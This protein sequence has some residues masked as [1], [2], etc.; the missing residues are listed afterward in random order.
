[1]N[2]L[3]KNALDSIAPEI[4][5]PDDIAAVLKI[6]AGS[7]VS[8]NSRYKV[9]FSLTDSPKFQENKE[10]YFPGLTIESENVFVSDVEQPEKMFKGNFIFTYHMDTK[11]WTRSMFLS[12]SNDKSIGDRVIS[13]IKIEL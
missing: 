13:N 6:E 8:V 12:C 1:M 2:E 7:M 3:Y 11:L 9:K 5:V 10:V 4:K